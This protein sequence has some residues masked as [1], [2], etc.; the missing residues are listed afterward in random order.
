V[1]VIVLTA[2]QQFDKGAACYVAAIPILNS[3]SKTVEQK[4]N[5]GSNAEGD[6]SNLLSEAEAKGKEIQSAAG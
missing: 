2:C 6:G 4:L 3:G 1:R 5:C